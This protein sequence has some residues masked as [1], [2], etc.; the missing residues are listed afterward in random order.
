[1][2]HSEHGALLLHSDLHRWNLSSDHEHRGEALCTKYKK[3]IPAVWFFL[4]VFACQFNHDRVE[5]FKVIHFSGSYQ[6]L[7]SLFVCSQ[8]CKG[9]WPVSDGESSES[10]NV[11]GCVCVCV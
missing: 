1:M 6:Q 11:L 3:N 10:Q 7:I 9:C 4:F 8:E 5:A 2:T